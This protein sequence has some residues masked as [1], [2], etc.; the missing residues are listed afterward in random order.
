[1]RINLTEPAEAEVNWPIPAVI[2]ATL[3]LNFF[4]WYGPARLFYFDTTTAYFGS[5]L[6]VTVVVSILFFMAPA[7]AAHETG[8]SLFSVV[9]GSFGVI[10]AIAFR[11]GAA[12][13]CVLWIARIST[14]AGLIAK[15][16]RDFSGVQ[17]AAFSLVLILFLL[18]TG[19]QSLKT[20]AKLALFTAKLGL[21][22][23]IVA[24]IRVYPNVSAA[25][26]HPWTPFRG[27]DA[28]SLM[29]VPLYVIGPMALLAADFGYRTRTRK[30]VGFVGLF[31]LALPLA[32]TLI[33]VSILQTAAHFGPNGNYANMM[34]A[35]V[36]QESR[37]Y[38]PLW[39]SIA[40]IT[41]FGFA[42][43][44]VQVLRSALGPLQQRSPV[45]WIALL[46][47]MI[48]AAAALSNNLSPAIERISEISA[49]VAA[50]IAA[51]LTADYLL[52][53]RRT[54][55]RFVDLFALLFV[56]LGCAAGGPTSFWEGSHYERSLALSILLP[57]AASFVSCLIGREIEYRVR[58]M[59]KL[60]TG[61][62]YL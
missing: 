10:P 59:W 58:R 14:T 21:A 25:L 20:T 40:M 16:N 34:S 28:L 35:L 3:F 55:A 17:L 43:F 24:A 44:N 45:L 48:A 11:I 52:R 60:F 33:A 12:G 9:E 6:G 27:V 4:F 38:Y 49:R 2:L 13:F 5:I 46:I 19:L 39:L 57:Y 53:G 51:V 29:A 37:K 61:V 56:I 54:S 42:R 30:D 22:L 8:R 47:C 15:I 36:G 41:I 23:L 50:A 32:C 31:G 26:S 18:A 62:C 7:L 1:M